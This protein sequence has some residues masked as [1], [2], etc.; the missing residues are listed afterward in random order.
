MTVTTTIAAL[1]SAASVTGTDLVPVYQT[2]T[3]RR[4]T[5]AQFAT[6]LQSITATGATTARTLQDMAAD[7]V[8]L[9][10]WGVN[11]SNSA[12]LN[13]T[14][15]QAALDANPTG[16]FDLPSSAT[17]YQ[18]LGPIYLS[19]STGRNFSGTFNA[20]G[21]TI[22]WTNS[23]AA[24]DT[25]VNMQKGFVARPKT[26]TI[27]SDTTGMLQ[28][29]FNGGTF[30][31]PTHGVAIY[32]ANS[33]G[34]GFNSIITKN[35]RYGVVMEVCIKQ[36]F[37]ACLFAEYT[38]AGVGL[39]M[40]SDTSKVYYGVSSSNVPNGNPAFSYWN[41]SPKFD[42]C[43][44]V[45]SVVGSMAH[46][47]DHGS[48]AEN[49]RVMIGC[50]IYSA[51]NGVA[52][53]GIIC[54]QG[55][56]DI[57]SSWSE[58]VNSFVRILSSNAAEGGAGTALTWVTGAEPSGTY[59]LANF[60]DGIASYFSAM[61]CFTSG[62]VIDYN[63]SGVQGNVTLGPNERTYGYNYYVQSL[64][65]TSSTIVDLGTNVFPV[66]FATTA[67]SGTGATAT[68]TFAALPA[69]P[70]V[71]TSVVIASVT[72]AGFNGTFTITAS[73]VTSVSYVNATL[74]PQTVAGTMQ[75][76]SPYKNV[77]NAGYMLVSDLKEFSNPVAWNNAV[78][79]AAAA[80]LGTAV[81][82]PYRNGSISMIRVA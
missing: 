29:T 60:P 75:Y 64:Y 8:P 57:I 51:N 1:P 48:Q 6:F 10:A 4:A 67:A 42:S 47:L 36:S 33:Q 3:T 13:A 59:T 79:D 46:I 73:T 50:Y 35:N 16:N 62:C 20:Q 24:V 18:V 77:V 68:I 2:A 49:V 53:Y 28:A 38:N 39:L 9:K 17:P 74:G 80:A 69:A 26:L 81:N 32:M 40:L 52:P 37:W 82:K 55:N 71:G 7:R 72:P 56:W 45:T 54:R 34:C 11:T 70:I 58:R 31:G 41:D 43:G 76:T 78:N 15:L 25:E 21:A 12:A 44:F 22:N 19:D 27:F 23:G 65:S 30:T 5:G 61:K 66:N 14:N 63:V